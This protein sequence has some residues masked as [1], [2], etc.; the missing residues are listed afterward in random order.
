MDDVDG[1]IHDVARDHRDHDAL[2]NRGRLFGAAPTQQRERE[3]MRKH[4]FNQWKIPADGSPAVEQWVVSIEEMGV[5]ERFGTY[6]EAR[7]FWKTLDTQP[8]EKC[9]VCHVVFTGNGCRCVPG[10][11]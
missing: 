9:V 1:H 10:F 4:L 2:T 8:V 7:D 6:E 5:F 3:E 11:I